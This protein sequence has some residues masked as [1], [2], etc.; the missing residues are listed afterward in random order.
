MALKIYSQPL[1]TSAFSQNGDFTNPLTDAFDGVAGT[2]LTKKYYVRNDA[3]TLYFTN[4]VVQPVY[5]TGVN[6]ID[7]T[8][9]YSWQL[10]AGDAEP[11]EEQWDEVSPANAISLSDLGS[12]SSEDIGTYLPFRLRRK[13]PAG[14]PVKAYTGVTLRISATQGLVA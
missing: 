1:P 3:S 7:G 2:T 11:L 12:V 10:I 13:V 5:L 9:G 4:I 6:I 14:A 8:D